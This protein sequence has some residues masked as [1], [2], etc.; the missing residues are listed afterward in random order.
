MRNFLI[1]ARREYLERV[2][3]KSFIIITL[4]LPILM[5]GATVVLPRLL[6]SGSVE[7]KHFVIVA[8]NASTA[9][10]LRDALKKAAEGPGEES[11]I[12]K[13]TQGSGKVSPR[14][15]LTADISTD[16][17]DAQ[18]TALTEKVNQKQLDGVIFGADDSLASGKISFYTRD[19]S[20]LTIQELVREGLTD[21]VRRDML[22]NKG[23]TRPE[24]DKILRPV[25]MDVLGPA[26]A[27]NPLAMYITVL[28]LVMIMY[29]AVMIYGAGV[30]RA[31]LEEKTSRVMEVMLATARPVEMLA[32]KILGVGA[33]GLTQMGIW[34][35]TG[36]IFG[37]FSVLSTGVDVKGIFSVKSMLFMGLFF[38]L[39]Y[40]MYS[41]LSA[42]IGAMANSDQDTQQL[43]II[44]MM[45]M[46]FAVMIMGFV[47]QSPNGAL[48][49]WTSMFP[50][51]A[52]LIMFM[53][54][55]I[56][57]PPLWQ[58]VLSIVLIIATTAGFVFLCARIYRVGILM[59]GKRATLPEIM[60]W[61]KYA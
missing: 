49:V 35:T 13:G 5:I 30:Q 40:F 48:G 37:A 58:I 53:R 44:A 3:T 12:T 39:G 23:L 27:G 31:I 28:A 54:I 43:Q 7:T 16:T 57:T 45:P 61:I 14:L 6:A 22:T 11:R 15:N 25:T 18:R 21:G 33:V 17:S 32:G 56:Q 38:L 24:I 41:T 26:G 4:L 59:Y 47:L 20:S 55:A 9:E 8:S 36:M 60:K 46:I 2:R 50:L 42:A 19:I 29:I 52:P 10:T 1:I 34:V 51:T